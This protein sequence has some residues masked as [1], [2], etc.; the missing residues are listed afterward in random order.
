LG[1]VV[2]ETTGVDVGLT[3]V[4]PPPGVLVGLTG[5]LVGVLLGLLVVDETGLG[6]V[7]VVTWLPG[8]HW[9]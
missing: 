9:K 7:V 3:D 5:V 4:V 1:V 6:V 8:R 2:G